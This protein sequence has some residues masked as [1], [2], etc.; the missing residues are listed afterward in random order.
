MERVDTILTGG[1]TLTM[2][3]NMQL[4]LNGAVAIRADQ[5]VAVGPAETISVQY[6]AEQIVDCSGQIIM[7]GL[8]NAHTHA[9]MTL[10]RGIA[11][12]LR[13]DVWL[14]GYIMPTERHFVT[15][16]FCRLGT[17]LACAEMIRSG[18]TMYADM[19]YFESEV[20]A[21]TADAGLRAVCGQTVLK[22]PTPDADSYDESLAYTRRFIE[23]W[24]GHPLIVP[25]IAPHAPYSC[26]D[27]LLETCRDIAKEY[28]VPLL[29]HLAEMKQEVED[30]RRD[31]GMPVIPRVKK[32]N[33]FE[34]K[35]L[36]AHCVHVDSGEIR[37][38]HNHDVGVAHCPTSNLK[39]ANG[40]API[41]EM[42]GREV[43]VGIG[44]DGAAS[45]NDLDMFEE[46]RLAAILA[47]GATLE[48]TTLP[49]KQALLMATRLGA[50]AMHQG[51]Y[52]GS[53]EPG[54][55]ADLIVINRQT[56]HNAPQFARDTDVIYSQIV[57]TSK[58]TDV[59]HVMVNGSWLMRDRRLLTVD[60]TSV[61][62]QANA[63]AHQI[64]TFL[65]ER[66]GSVINKLIAIGG[67]QQEESFEIQVKARISGPEALQP[68]LTDHRAQLVKT[69]HYRQ[70]DTYFVF[71]DE[72]QGRVR[73]RED[74]ALDDK[75]A[76]TNVR[77]RLTYTSPTKEREFDE[78]VLLSRSQFIAPADRP[79]RFYREY[80]RPVEE[81]GLEKERRRWHLL[82]KGVLFYINLDT[83]INPAVEGQFVE[84]KARTWSRRDAEY[85]A[86]LIREMLADI[87]K[88]TPE[89]R[90][91]KEYVEFLPA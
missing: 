75:A 28:D 30:S 66:E 60:E 35:T 48:P 56:L 84:I 9:P 61:I 1:V 16:E 8:V 25:A 31:F 27:E 26:T 32:L 10:L 77:S 78:A 46:M 4:F 11:D 74:D 36:A 49:A 18:I 67:V 65:V 2:N 50:E 39:L 54:K 21:A 53:I 86:G 3:Q 62:A 47:K 63:L 76:V 20:A 52:T 41:A 33:L 34:A 83:M 40:I 73:Y 37:T 88:L 90:I 87:L 68:L 13:F 14:L 45:N 82:Y 71:A 89:A 29:I 91:H 57:Y 80:F 64:D 17:L 19:Y 38:L 69:T 55:R 58:S 6:Q 43:K 12:D 85:K 23:Q 42:L 22:F 5:I 44:T 70:Y 81:R 59:L 7:P 51:A 72:A 79:L 24:K 15:P